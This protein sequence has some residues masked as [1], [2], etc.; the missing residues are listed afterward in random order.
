MKT[1]YSWP[2]PIRMGR[3]K[4]LA[5][6]Q[7]MSNLP[8]RATS[9]GSPRARTLM[10]ASVKAVNGVATFSNLI[11]TKAGTYTLDATNGQ[12]TKAVSNSIKIS[13]AEARKIVFVSEPS[14]AK[15]GQSIG[16]FTVDVEDQYGNL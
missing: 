3:P 9:M 6:F 15:E 5:K 14:N 16:T 11:L 13:P 10:A 8:M 7:L 4:K 1:P 2:A 12:D